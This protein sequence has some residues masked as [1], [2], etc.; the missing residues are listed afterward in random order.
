[1]EKKWTNKMGCLC[2]S[3]SFTSKLAPEYGNNGLSVT[4][5]KT[6]WNGDAHYTIDSGGEGLETGYFSVY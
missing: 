2:N 5:V 4:E 6:E 3:D 1:M